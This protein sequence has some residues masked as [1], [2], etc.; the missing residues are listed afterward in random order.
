MATAMPL[1]KKSPKSKNELVT[2][3]TCPMISSKPKTSFLSTK[4][5]PPTHPQPTNSSTH[6]TDLQIK[7]KP[8]K[9]IHNPGSNT[10]KNTPL[11]II[12]KKSTKL[13]LS[14]NNSKCPTACPKCSAP[15]TYPITTANPKNP[16]S[17]SSP[18]SS[19]D[20]KKLPTTSPT[21]NI[22]ATS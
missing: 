1:K 15:T 5:W 21:P 14:A 3:N 17:K 10:S 4:K 11:N 22:S 18:D 9:P 12:H 19:P 20:S 8:F 16:S 6:S 13:T 7:S 2:K